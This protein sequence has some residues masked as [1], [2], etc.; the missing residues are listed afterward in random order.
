MNNILAV[1]FAT[2]LGVSLSTGA[3][4]KPP[5]DKSNKPASPEESNKGGQ[6]RGLDRA[7]EVAGE[8]GKQGR[9][10]AREAQKNHPK[11]PKKERAARSGQAE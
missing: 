3:W 7:D 1:L 10:R 2:V 4:S 9:E 5:S 11:K 6:L 8:H